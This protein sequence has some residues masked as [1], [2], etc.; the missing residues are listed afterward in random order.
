[1]EAILKNL[2]DS[3]EPEKSVAV[4]EM[5]VPFKVNLSYY[6]YHWLC[7]YTCVVFFS[8]CVEPI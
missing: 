6:D 4:D 1:M 7:Y 8:D 3:V 2:K 5:M